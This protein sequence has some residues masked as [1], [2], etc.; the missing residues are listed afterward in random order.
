MSTPKILIV[1]DD[2]DMLEAY[3]LAFSQMLVE[4]ITT[5]DPLE[6][7]R[8]IATTKFAVIL[9]DLRMPVMTGVQLAS[10]IRSDKLNHDTKLFII[11]GAVTDEAVEK[12]ER[13]GIVE[14]I[15]K[16]VDFSALTEKVKQFAFPIVKKPLG[17]SSW[18]ASG[19]TGCSLN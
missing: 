7:V 19:C 1:D 5:P 10:Y 4:V 2:T 13:L 3:A 11:S 15:E 17:Y 12:L 16:P 9:S 14:I 18:Q 6:A 8:I